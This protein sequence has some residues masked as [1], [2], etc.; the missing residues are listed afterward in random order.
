MS[1][2]SYPEIEAKDDFIYPKPTRDEKDLIFRNKIKREIETYSP[3]LAKKLKKLINC[4]EDF[5]KRFGRGDASSHGNLDSPNHRVYKD[6]SRKIYYNP[7]SFENLI[8]NLLRGKVGVIL[9]EIHLP[10]IFNRID[11]SLL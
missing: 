5:E 6:R 10:R 4:L 1:K 9:E 3:F 7:L 11:K 8:E 2:T